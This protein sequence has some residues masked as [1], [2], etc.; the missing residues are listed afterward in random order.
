[1][2]SFRSFSCMAATAKCI[3]MSPGSCKERFQDS[4]DYRG[5]SIS[6]GN[7]GSGSWG[8]R[9][10]ESSLHKETVCPKT[11]SLWVGVWIWPLFPLAVYLS[12]ELLWGGI[13]WCLDFCTVPDGWGLSAG[14]VSLFGSFL[15]SWKVYQRLHLSPI[16]AL[17]VRSHWHIASV[18]NSFL[19]KLSINARAVH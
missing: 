6:P 2:I 8:V 15:W 10:T 18:F 12:M 17:T 19:C 11:A 7:F 13:P 1:M 14:H 4:Q 16:I 5:R 9:L 3:P